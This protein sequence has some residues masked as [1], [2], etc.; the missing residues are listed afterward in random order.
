MVKYGLSVAFTCYNPRKAHC[1]VNSCVLS[2]GVANLSLCVTHGEPEK[3]V[4][5]IW[6]NA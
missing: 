5:D 2:C 1:Y 3:K 6:K 4:K